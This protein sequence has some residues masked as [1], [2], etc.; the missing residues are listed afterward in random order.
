MSLLVYASLVFLYTLIRWYVNSVTAY[1]RRNSTTSSSDTVTNTSLELTTRSW[2]VSSP[3]SGNDSSVDL[4]RRDSLTSSSDS[5]VKTTRHSPLSSHDTSSS[6]K[7]L[8]VG[9]VVGL[10]LLVLIIVII[11]V[12]IYV[13]KSRR[14]KRKWPT[15]SN[16]N[17]S[18]LQ[19]QEQNNDNIENNN[20]YVDDSAAA[21]SMASDTGSFMFDSEHVSNKPEE[22][23]TVDQY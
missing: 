20:A 23:V 6:D 12:I 14:R 16:M 19:A 7:T 2:P 3:D 11:V 8:I 4:I 21:V 9:L 18:N 17:Y 22:T 10:F 1:I 5:G 13:V 15:V